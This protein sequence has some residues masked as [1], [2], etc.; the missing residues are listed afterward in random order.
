MLKDITGDFAGA[1]VLAALI[2]GHGEDTLPLAEFGEAFNKQ[3][4]QL[5]RR[6]IGIDASNCAIET[7]ATDSAFFNPGA[8]MTMM[9]IEMR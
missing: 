3:I 1:G 8:S 6:Q 5:L 7:H 4:V 2:G 9:S